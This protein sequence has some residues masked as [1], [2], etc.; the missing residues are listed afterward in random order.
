M[1]RKESDH[2]GHISALCISETSSGW[3]RGG[4]VWKVGF[5]HRDRH[6][7]TFGESA[8]KRVSRHQWSV[9]GRRIRDNLFDLVSLPVFE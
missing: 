2:A 7:S 6:A 5:G 3:R 8:E 9:N 1:A 4:H